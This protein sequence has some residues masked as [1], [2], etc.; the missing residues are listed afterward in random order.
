M[1]VELTPDKLS[2]KIPL[3]II[4]SDVSNT[5]LQLFSS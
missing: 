4:G 2:L 3:E 1:P 5:R